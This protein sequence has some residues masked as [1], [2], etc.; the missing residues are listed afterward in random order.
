MQF[1]A[2]IATGCDFAQTLLQN[3]SLTGRQLVEG[4]QVAWQ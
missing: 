1:A 4:L 3:T 2:K